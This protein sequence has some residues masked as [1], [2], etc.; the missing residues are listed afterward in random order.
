LGS[1]FP[2]LFAGKSERDGARRFVRIDVLRAGPAVKTG[3]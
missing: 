3:T 2:I 1:W